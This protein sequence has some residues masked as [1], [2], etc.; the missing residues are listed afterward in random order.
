[1]KRE[2]NIFKKLGKAGVYKWLIF[3]CIFSIIPIVAT[4]KYQIHLANEILIM[5]LFA[6]AF[7]LLFGYTGMLSFGQAA[8]YGIGAYSIGILM[9]KTNCPY[10]IAILIG[11]A[12]SASIA[13]LL[14]LLCIRLKGVFFTM[15][16]LAFGQL[17][18]GIVFKWYKFTGGD[19]GIQGISLPG[20]FMSAY[21]YYYFCLIIVLISLYICSRIV[22]SPFGCIMKCIHHNSERTEFIGIRIRRY[23]LAVY[24]LSATFIGLAGALFAGYEHSIHPNLM[25]WTKSGEVILMSIA[26][27]FSSFFG[28]VIGAA[29]ILIVEDVVGARTEFWE[30]WIGGIMLLIVLLFP[31]GVAGSVYSNW[32]NIRKKF[33][34]GNSN[35]KHLRS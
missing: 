31:N 11:I 24:I 34:I 29:I 19:N 6:V 17:L 13:L 9:T 2:S 15:L 1:V 33:A 27:G 20:F 8:F 26:G 23:Q 14:G 21:N 28:P 16:T 22:S 18:W 7:N 3:F 12:L 10:W 35:G 5:S 32:V 25:Y 4:S 30:I